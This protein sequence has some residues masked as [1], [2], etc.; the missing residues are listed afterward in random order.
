MQ[1]DREKSEKTGTFKKE[2]VTF[3]QNLVGTLHVVCGF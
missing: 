1:M 3:L 2:V